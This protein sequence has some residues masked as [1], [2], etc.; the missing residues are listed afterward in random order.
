M[1]L[2]KIMVYIFEGDHKIVVDGTDEIN[3]RRG[4]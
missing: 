1:S 3:Y 4:Q 2:L